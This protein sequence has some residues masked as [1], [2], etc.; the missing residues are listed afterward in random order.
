MDPIPGMWRSRAVL[1]TIGLLPALTAFAWATVASTGALAMGLFAQ[2]AAIYA[3]ARLT[4]DLRRSNEGDV[5]YVSGRR[6]WS[7]HARA[8]LLTELIGLVV[9]AATAVGLGTMLAV[10]DQPNALMLS[11]VWMVVCLLFIWHL[12]CSW[13]LFDAYM[14]LTQADY[15]RGRRRAEWVARRGP[16]HL[17]A[18]ALDTAIQAQLSSGDVVGAN[19]RMVEHWDGSIAN[20]APVMLRLRIARGEPGLAEQW[21]VGRESTTI[22]HR[23]Q[24]ALVRAHLAFHQEA[25]RE[26]LEATQSVPGLPPYHQ[27]SL[28]VIAMATHQAAGEPAQAA[29]VLRT[30][31]EGLKPYAFVAT[32]FPDVG[33]WLRQVDPGYAA[34]PSHA[35]FALEPKPR[36]PQELA[37]P[38]AAPAKAVSRRLRQTPRHGAVPVEWLPLMAPRNP[39][40]FVFR[41]FTA[42]LA[43]LCTWGLGVLVFLSVGLPGELEPAILGASSGVLFVLGLIA[44]MPALQL[45]TTWRHST[46][47]AVLDHGY[48]IPL[49]SWSWWWLTQQLPFHLALL[50][51]VGTLLAFVSTELFGVAAGFLGLLSMAVLWGAWVR[52]RSVASTRLG[53][54]GRGDR[55]IAK[56]R[57]MVSSWWYP[58][59]VSHGWLALVLLWSGRPEEGEEVLRAALPRAPHL[60]SLLG[61]WSATRGEVDLEHLLALDVPERLGDRYRQAMTLALAA[62]ATPQVSAFRDRLNHTRRAWPGIAESLPNR[63]G[64]WLEHLSRCLDARLEGQPAPAVPEALAGLPEAW[65]GA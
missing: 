38:Y 37:S 15:V 20:A 47:A 58:Y 60:G 5:L 53:L 10:Q 23:F 49:R 32:A 13:V 30:F 21:L 46:P 57:R 42:G 52:A 9:G 65:R 4:G 17:R 24:E 51:A 50:L 16:P 1:A 19:R 11:A 59:P 43:G 48:W 6:A 31:P 22:Y 56:L 34:P 39:S 7:G 61:W 26:A 64:T 36:A 41:A 54:V 12:S 55:A 18:S 35:D 8:A 14:A 28:D 25:W 27:R 45:I 62:L 2:G 63:F 40:W 29:Q 44:F 33:R 3:T